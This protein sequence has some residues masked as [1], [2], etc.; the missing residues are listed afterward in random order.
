[1]A[2]KLLQVFKGIPANYWKIVNISENIILNKTTIDLGLY[3]NNGARK[4]SELN[5]LE[6]KLVEI[7]G[8]DLTRAQIYKAIKALPYFAN[9]VDC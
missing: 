1:M 8:I 6:H 2:L 3:I 7:H 9:A 5:I 4:A